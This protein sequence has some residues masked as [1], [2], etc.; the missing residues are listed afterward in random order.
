VD[1]LGPEFEEHDRRQN[2]S[3]DPEDL[4]ALY[5]DIVD[6]GHDIRV[7]GKRHISRLRQRRPL[8][9]L[10]EVLP[11]LTDRQLEALVEAHDRGYYEIPRETTTADIA[12]AMGVH[13][14]TVEEHLRRAE[15]K[16]VD[17]IIPYIR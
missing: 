15:A 10:E 11:D 5:R 4:S 3:V 17:E 12:D 2:R 14:R 13:R 7:E 16:V 8:L 9:T 1:R 6:E